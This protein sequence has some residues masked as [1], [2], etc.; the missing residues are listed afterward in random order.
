MIFIHLLLVISIY[1]VVTDRN[2]S[3]KLNPGLGIFYLEHLPFVWKT[4]KLQGE[5]KW[6]GSS[7]WK[8]S[9]KKVIPFFL[10]LLK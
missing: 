6:N 8:F 4:Q 7:W 1:F 2:C 5:F 10:F 3:S 9:R